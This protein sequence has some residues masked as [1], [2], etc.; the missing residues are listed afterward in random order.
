M[1][2]EAKGDKQFCS[3]QSN[4]MIIFFLQGVYVL[5][6]AFWNFKFHKRK[7]TGAV[8]INPEKVFHYV[9]IW[10]KISIFADIFSPVIYAFDYA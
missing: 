7:G 4:H 5:I 8:C 2:V 10:V 6:V 3:V 1:Y 9:K